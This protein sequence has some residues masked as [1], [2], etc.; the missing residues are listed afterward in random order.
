MYKYT[1]THIHVYTYVKSYVVSEDFHLINRANH[2]IPDRPSGHIR[3]GRTISIYNMYIYI[4]IYGWSRAR[5]PGC[6][7]PPPPPSIPPFL[8]L[9]ATTVTGIELVGATIFETVLVFG[10]RRMGSTSRC[11]TANCRCDWDSWCRVSLT[12]ASFR[13][14]GQLPLEHGTEPTTQTTGGRRRRVF[15]MLRECTRAT[16]IP[17]RQRLRR[18]RKTGKTAKSSVV[19]TAI[20]MT[21]QLLQTAVSI[22]V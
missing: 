14:A 16:A 5:I 19:A 22:A 10:C 20:R 12:L 9:S 8:G 21:I 6:Y 3:S 1:C 15:A 2:I 11:Q 4:Y 17:Q 13:H 18:Q 7:P